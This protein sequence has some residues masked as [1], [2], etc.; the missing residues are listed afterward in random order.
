MCRLLE[1]TRASTSSNR[2]AP[3]FVVP[4]NFRQMMLLALTSCPW[5]SRGSRHWA[6]PRL[7]CCRGLQATSRTWAALAHCALSFGT[8]QKSSTCCPDLRRQ[9]SINLRKRTRKQFSD[10][11]RSNEGSKLRLVDGRLEMRLAFCRHQIRVALLLK[12]SSAHLW[13]SPATSRCF[14]LCSWMMREYWSGSH[15]FLLFCAQFFGSHNI[16]IF[17]FL[18]QEMLNT[19]SQLCLAVKIKR[20]HVTSSGFLKKVYEYRS[21]RASPL[22]K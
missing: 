2:R 18:Q 15:E 22:K 4:L 21:I 8:R 20:L 3:V 7:P 12:S 10:C 19:N 16:W 6:W 9:R 13:L 14:R 11:T 17:C 1:A 5:W